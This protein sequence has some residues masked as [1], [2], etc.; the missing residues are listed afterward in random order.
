MVA[1]CATEDLLLGNVPVPASASAYVQDAADEMDSIIGLQY[2]TPVILDENIQAQRAGF[3]LLKKINVWLASGRLLMALDAGGEDDQLHQYAKY[4][5]EQALM[6]LGQIQDGTVILPGADPV[7]PGTDQRITGPQA[8]FQD[9]TSVVEQF[10]TVFGNPA[11]SSLLAC[12]PPVFYGG[13]N[14]YTW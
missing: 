11:Q 2:V 14:P 1:Y 10:G 7:N 4:L 12:R 9:D 8:A 5:V 3:L 13:R 6:A